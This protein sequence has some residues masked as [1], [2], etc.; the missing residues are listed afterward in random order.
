MKKEY[1]FTQARRGAV[2]THKGKSR[3]T[4]WLVDSVLEAFRQ[5]A[6]QSG[7]G[8]QTLIN[9][10]LGEYLANTAHRLMRQACGGLSVKN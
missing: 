5:L 3:I 8:Y 1:D 9:Q 6:E 4:I 7:C 2:L 10:A